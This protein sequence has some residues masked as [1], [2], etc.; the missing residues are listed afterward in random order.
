MDTA[1]RTT[2]RG[3]CR[4]AVARA[5]ELRSRGAVLHVAVPREHERVT[6]QHSMIEL[7]AP[8]QLHF[9]TEEIVSSQAQTSNHQGQA[10]IS[11]FDV[12]F[13]RAR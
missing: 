12:Q 5:R 9:L 6:L 7:L 10:P 3:V 1:V 8:Q 11:Q 2:S 4:K 13:D